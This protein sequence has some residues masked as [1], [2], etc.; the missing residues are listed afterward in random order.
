MF[1]TDPRIALAETANLPFPWLIFARRLVHSAYLLSANADR[2]N[3]YKDVRNVACM[4]AGMAIECYFKAYYVAC[5]NKL[6]DGTSFTKLGAHDLPQMADRV[7]YSV[8]PEQRRVLH[9]LSMWVKVK[10]RYPVPVKPD[11]IK[12]HPSDAEANPF[13]LHLLEWND[14]SE[15]VTMEII[16]EAEARIASKRQG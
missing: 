16:R 9:Y 1:A 10:G 7:A 2:D 14:R 13:T 3:L 5:G 6:H 12:I 4:C 11:D 8:T 15:D